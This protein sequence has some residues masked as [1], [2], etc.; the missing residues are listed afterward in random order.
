MN[1]FATSE[2]PFESAVFLD[3]KRVVKMILESAQML[4]NAMHHYGLAGPY[5]ITH[6]NHPCSV[7]VRTSRG[8]FIWLLDHFFG[9]CKEYTYRYGKT[10]K[11]ESL[12]NIFDSAIEYI[13]QG[14]QT[15]FVNCA[16]N[17]EFGLDFRSEQDT[18]RAY[19]KYLF[20]RHTTD[21]RP[22]T[23]EVKR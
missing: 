4:S 5:K 14:Q 8:N 7:W 1:I 13:P 16:A 15:N 20:A 6:A 23:W 19:R 17:K 10:H 2:C 9:L 22:P 11:C 21:K 3:N 12:Y 18:C